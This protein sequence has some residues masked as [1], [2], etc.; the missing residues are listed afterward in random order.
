MRR[1]EAV[2]GLGVITAMLD[3]AVVQDVIARQPTQPLAHMLRP[4]SMKRLSTS[5][6]LPTAARLIGRLANRSCVYWKAFELPPDGGVSAGSLVAL[7]AGASTPVT[8]QLPTTGRDGRRSEFPDQGRRPF[9][10]REVPSVFEFVPVHDVRVTALSP[11]PRGAKDLLG[12]DGDSGRNSNLGRSPPSK[13]LPG[14]AGG[15]RSRCPST[16]RA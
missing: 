7:S 1:L 13:A 12:E 4:R 14:E 8:K 11:A 16:N 3:A 5:P 2:Y 6:T 9:E 10:R 15:R